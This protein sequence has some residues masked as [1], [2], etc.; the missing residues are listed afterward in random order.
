MERKFNHGYKNAEFNGVAVFKNIVAA[1]GWCDPSI[2]GSTDHMPLTEF[3]HPQPGA[4]MYSKLM[5]QLPALGGGFAE[6]RFNG[7][8]SDGQAGLWAAGYTALQAP[9]VIIYRTLIYHSNNDN[10]FSLV[11]S[12]NIDSGVYQDNRLL[13]VSSFSPNDAWAVGQYWPRNMIQP[14]SLIMRWNGKEW[15]LVNAPI[16]NHSDTLLGVVSISPTDAWAVGLSTNAIL[17]KNYTMIQ[18]WDGQS[19]SII[20]SPNVDLQSN[21]LQ[22]ICAVGKNDL[23]AVGYSYDPGSPKEEALIMHYDGKGWTLDKAFAGRLYGVSA[24][25]PNDI[26]AVGYHLLPGVKA[27][28]MLHYDGKKWKQVALPSVSSNIAHL[29]SVYALSST[30]AW[31]VGGVYH[32]SS[33]I[34]L[35]MRWNGNKWSVVPSQ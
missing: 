32:G 22:S 35:A 9:S 30:E 15:E 20:A 18:H 33:I 34:S 5:P 31:A 19:W 26:W 28:V 2:L 11:Y 14:R 8:S 25:G 1:V 3:W 13:S 21:Q 16:I 12:P 4:M 10:P 7:T 29:N 24:S 27:P 23:W 17:A 6:G